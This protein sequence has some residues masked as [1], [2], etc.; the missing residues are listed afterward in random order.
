MLAQP[1]L[2]SVDVDTPFPSQ[3]VTAADLP[4][5]ATLD[6]MIAKLRHLDQ[7]QALIE[8]SL[9]A[10]VD[11]APIEAAF[12]LAGDTA[13]VV[14]RRE[15]DSCWCKSFL[16][17]ASAD[18]SGDKDEILW[19]RSHRLIHLSPLPLQAAVL[20]VGRLSTGWIGILRFRNDT[21]F[22]KSD[23]G[24]LHFTHQLLANQQYHAQT[25]QRFRESLVGILR[26]LS[27]VIEAKDSYTCGHSERVARI[28]VVLAEH[29]R[30]GVAEVK[31]LFMAGLLHDLG[32][33]GV[34]DRI[35]LKDGPLSAKEFEIMKT[36]PVIG[37]KIVSQIRS[38]AKLRPGVRHHH[39]R[40]DGA[41]YPDG[42]AGAAIPL[43]ARILAVADTCDALMSQ[44]RYR[45]ARTPPEID[46]I[47]D[48][49]S[50]SQLDPDILAHFRECR[51]EIYP[52]IFRK[53]IGD[54]AIH[55]VGGL[56]AGSHFDLH[57]D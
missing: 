8:S 13:T 29:M 7:A 35:L 25:K 24:L 4:P 14:G 21:P 37:D 10:I 48:S 20:R 45:P 15:L 31:N 53:G 27:E 34:P 2:A 40:F 1:R 52:P 47:L 57:V 22:T 16:V 26:G 38:F 49:I 42:L 30:L 9:Q 18:G 54:S 28:A 43:D 56:I 32:K 12:Y 50:G 55:A 36:H 51:D 19:Q 5:W 6:Q 17:L 11:T 41:G 3:R 44:R 23:L 46:S 33:V 39:E